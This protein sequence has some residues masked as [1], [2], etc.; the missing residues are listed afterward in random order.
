MTTIE[1]APNRGLS[2]PPVFLFV[3]DT[4]LE[5]ADHQALKQ[6][7]VVSLNLLPQSAMIGMITYGTM[8]RLR[9]TL[10][11]HFAKPSIGAC[12]RDRLQ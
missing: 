4:C 1:Y 7:L 5:D 10:H 8:V 3:V 6:Q 11:N 12:T 9:S 2:V